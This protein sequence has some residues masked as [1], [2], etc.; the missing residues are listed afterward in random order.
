MF[1]MDVMSTVLIAMLIKTC[2]AS[3]F[4]GWGP[5]EGFGHAGRRPPQD[6]P[7]SNFGFDYFGTTEN[8]F[9]YR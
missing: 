9:N 3:P 7:N 1:A 2:I 4:G 5:G 6:N 8:R